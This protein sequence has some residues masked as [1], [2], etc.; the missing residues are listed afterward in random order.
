MPEFKVLDYVDA[1][2]VASEAREPRASRTPAVWPSEASADRIDKTE[3]PVVGACHRKSF[4]RM[5][6][7]SVTNQIDPVGAWRFVTGR[8]VE[9]HLTTLAIAS[10]PPIYVANGVRHF[11][12]DIYLPFELDLVVK[13]P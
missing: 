5:V 2:I 13:D 11:V 1:A 10:K 3:G 8:S 7:W 4:G 9:T 12:R 6:G